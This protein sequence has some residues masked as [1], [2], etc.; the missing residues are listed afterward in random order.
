[1]TMFFSNSKIFK[2]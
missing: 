1:M 2:T